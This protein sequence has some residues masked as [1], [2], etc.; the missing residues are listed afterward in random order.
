MTVFAQGEAGEPPRLDLERAVT[1]AL[2]HDPT[3]KIAGLSFEEARIAYERNRAQNLL[4]ENRRSRL[5]AENAYRSA[6]VS[7]ADT[8][9]D[10]AIGAVERY[11]AVLSDS[12]NVSLNEY[13][14]Q[15]ARENLES[16]RR[17][18]EI[19]SAGEIDLREADLQVRSAT[20]SLDSARRT[21]EERR[22]EL[23]RS[24]GLSLDELGALD[25]SIRVSPPAYDLEAGI[26]AAKE[27]SPSLFNAS[28][29]VELAEIDLEEA[30]AAGAAELDIRA[31][32]LALEKARLQLQEAE[33]SIERSV[34]QSYSNLMQAWTSLTIQEERLAMQ[35]LRYD[36]T[37][38][39][40]EAGLTTESER[41]SAFISLTDQRASRL[42]SLAQYVNALLQYKKLIG[43]APSLDRGAGAGGNGR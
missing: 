29:A 6:Q 40:F 16:V 20:L 18:V 2:E 8:L 25:E 32:R 14:L 4:S 3:A 27:R 34:R 35:E 24:L 11:L 33:H 38:R 42:S 10:V 17:K 5:S 30:I 7:H 22:I 37:L 36:V 43:E 15:A 23:A 13:R 19:D 31:A 12:L 21:F 39:Q 41:L 26:A 28:S 1:L 9:A